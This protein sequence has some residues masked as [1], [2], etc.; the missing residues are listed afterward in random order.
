MAGIFGK[1]RLAVAI[2]VGLLGMLAACSQKTA[3]KDLSRFSRSC[4]PPVIQQFKAVDAKPQPNGT[5]LVFFDYSYTVDSDGSYTE[6]VSGFAANWQQSWNA[7]GIHTS[8]GVFESQPVQKVAQ[9]VRTES[10]TL[11]TS[12]GNTAAV[13]NVSLDALTAPPPPGC[14][15]FLVIDSRGSGEKNYQPSPPGAAFLAAF[16]KDNPGKVVWGMDN[17]YPAS[18]TIPDMVGAIV[19]ISFLGAYHDS[20]VIGKEWLQA[21]IAH[22][23]KSCPA[24]KMVLVGYSQGAQVTAD[25]YQA[26]V[27]LNVFGV[28]LFGDPYFNGEDLATDT[29]GYEEGRNGA[30]GKRPIFGKQTYGQVLSF[31]HEHDPV[32]Q[33]KHFYRKYKLEVHKNYDNASDIR[34]AAWFFSQS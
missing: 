9:N 2:A 28:V 34:Y 10:L 19:K 7:N 15:N 1:K 23:A 11:A 12:C 26:G 16:G 33:G 24:T 6:S 32:C 5:W 4:R 22:V 21:E 18:G 13:T 17:P 30:L 14:A 31:C 27:S 3:A 25:V 8:K 29:A 20:V